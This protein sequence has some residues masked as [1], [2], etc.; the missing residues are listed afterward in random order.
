MKR[1]E[2]VF[3]LTMGNYECKEQ[4]YLEL[5]SDLVLRKR[6]RRRLKFFLEK[7][8]G[9][10]FECNIKYDPE[11]NV[12]LVPKNSIRKVAGKFTK[13]LREVGYTGDAPKYKSF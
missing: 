10:S 6:A 4:I 3:V 13:L 2:K 9:D 12:A 8:S 5:K 1:R 7:A 11:T